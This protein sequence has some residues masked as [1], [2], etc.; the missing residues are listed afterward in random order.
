MNIDNIIEQN[1]ILQKK[2]V[3]LEKEIDELKINTV[4]AVF[5]NKIKDFINQIENN[6]IK[7]INKE[8]FLYINN[9][10]NDLEKQ[11]KDNIILQLCNFLLND[12]EI[13][14]IDEPKLVI[15]KLNKFINFIN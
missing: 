7:D 15:D 5:K 6:N 9:I 13:Y 11:I 10:K 1:I 3:E 8:L 4:K 12:N 2:I 14:H